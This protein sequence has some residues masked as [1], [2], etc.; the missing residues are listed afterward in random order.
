M[1]LYVLFYQENQV[2]NPL[3]RCFFIIFFGSIIIVTIIF[4]LKNEKYCGKDQTNIYNS[5]WGFII[6][7]D[8]QELAKWFLRPRDIRGIVG[9]KLLVSILWTTSYEIPQC[10]NLVHVSWE[11]CKKKIN[12]ETL[13]LRNCCYF[14]NKDTGMEIKIKVRE[15]NYL[16]LTSVKGAF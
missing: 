13:G 3:S 7:L 12:L 10:N 14:R 5:P 11:N 1:V 2:F 16:K 9:S 8:P 15:S 4:F 6:Y